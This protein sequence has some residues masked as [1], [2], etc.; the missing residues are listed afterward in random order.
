MEVRMVVE[1]AVADAMPAQNA[2]PIMP[3]NLRW[4]EGGI[5]TMHRIDIQVVDYSATREMLCIVGR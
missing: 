4:A 2:I 5:Q 3:H 1:D